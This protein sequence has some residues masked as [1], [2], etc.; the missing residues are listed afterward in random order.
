VSPFFRAYACA[1]Q[2]IPLP[3]LS[4]NNCSIRYAHVLGLRPKGVMFLTTT[5]G[6]EMNIEIK[7]LGGLLQV[8]GHNDLKGAGIKIM[9]ALENSEGLFIDSLEIQDSKTGEKMIIRVPAEG[10]K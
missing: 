9:C 7:V 2:V 4:F 6:V 3:L 10:G 5:K 8:Q 1:K